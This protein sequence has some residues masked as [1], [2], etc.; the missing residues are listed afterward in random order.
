MKKGHYSHSAKNARNTATKNSSDVAHYNCGSL[1]RTPCT[2]KCRLNIGI[3]FEA[4]APRKKAVPSPT[5]IPNF[6]EEFK[7][8]S[9]NLHRQKVAYCYMLRGDVVCF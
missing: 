5:G 9:P 4:P 3:R 1:R 2:S 6:G 8:I 7:D